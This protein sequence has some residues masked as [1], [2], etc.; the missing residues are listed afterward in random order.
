MNEQIAIQK[1][2]NEKFEEIRAKNPAFSLRAFSRRLD[3]SPSTLTRILSGTRRVSRPLAEQLCDKLMLDPQ[4]RSDILGNFPQRKK[5][6]QA[7]RFH[8]EVDPGYLQLTADQFRIIGEWYH[9]AI[10]SLLKTKG[11]KSDPE[12]IAERLGISVREAITALDRL[13]RLEMIQ[14]D[15]S[16]EWTRTHPRF[17]TT[18]DVMNLSLKKAH[19]QYLELGLEALAHVPTE[20][21]DFTAITMP[22]NPELLPKAKELIRKFQDEL[23]ALLESE[24][25]TEVYKFCTQLI[26]LT[27]PKNHSQENE[28]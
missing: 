10:L 5:Y 8:A 6:R 27:K 15:S 24:P 23:S 28:K 16:G 18:D 4:E 13:E 12:W 9:F 7:S 11:F 14:K 26:P 21:R 19:R 17:R 2:L 25:G 3:I 1:Q 22:T 20:L